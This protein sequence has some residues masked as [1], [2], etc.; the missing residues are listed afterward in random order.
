MA[1]PIHWLHV[2]QRPAQG[3][4][5]LKRYPVY[6]YQHT[7]VNQGWFDTASCD[8][9]VYSQ[10]EGQLIL[11][12]YLGSFIQIFVDNPVVPIWEGFINRIIF[13]TGNESWTVSLDEM[14]NRVSAIYTAAANAT[15][16]TAIVDNT[17]SQAIYGIK[18]DQIEFGPDATVATQRTVLT[19][20][21]LAQK[22]FPQTSVTMGQGNAMLVHFECLGI[23]HTLEWQKLFLAA[24]GP[25]VFNTR[26]IQYLGLVVNGTTFFDNTDTSQVTANAATTPTQQ[27]GVGM[28]E[29]IVKIAEAG[30]GSNYFV[31]G[32]TPTN[33]NTKKRVLYYR[34]ANSATQYTAR[35]SD[36]LTIRN[37]YGRIQPAWTIVPDCAIQITDTLVGSSGNYLTDPT[38]TYIQSIQYDANSQRIQWAGADNT[39]ARAAF[40]LH[41]SWKPVAKQFGAP[42]RTI[43]T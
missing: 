22:A 5:F 28:W 17:A 12:H 37:A 26:I 34:V 1:I 33:P 4:G 13:N 40:Q 3:T 23:Y 7:I 32:I 30:D 16:E 20:T 36:N 24:A 35:Q 41:R 6:N 14:A 31:T 39:S 25:A 2:Y 38:V 11:D 9:A 19:N 27:R 21:I 8:V 43:V 15:T 42:F 29:A 18:Q 10:T